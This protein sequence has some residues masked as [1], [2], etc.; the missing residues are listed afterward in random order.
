MSLSTY[1]PHTRY[2]K[3]F[4]HQVMSFI[5]V[6]AVIFASGTLGF[7]IGSQRAAQ[8]V[9]S[10]EDQLQE[11]R[12][13]QDKAESALTQMR[14]EAQ[15]AVMRYEQL[16]SA[17]EEKI[18]EGPMEELVALVR[19]QLDEGTDPE[20]LAFVIRAARAPQNCTEPE[21]R[22][23]VI[24]TPAYKGPESQIE[25]GGGKIV[26]R[27]SGVSARNEQGAPEAW[28]DPSKTVSVAF[29]SAGVSES[30]EGIM[31]LHHSLVA[32]DREYRFTVE[33]GARSFAKVTFDSCDYP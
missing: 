28:Y 21:T 11:M 6:A 18:P 2:R 7:W 31:P 3:R 17:V 29:T 10:L 33:E 30:K 12:A 15:T 4:I 23:F 32:G 22:R 13:A 16:Q 19:T 27:G 9:G 20:R 25:I 8:H 5:F 24:S 14:T 26:I 1:D